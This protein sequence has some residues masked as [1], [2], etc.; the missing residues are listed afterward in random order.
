MHIRTALSKID[1]A[2]TVSMNYAPGYTATISYRDS[3]EVQG[4]D[5]GAEVEPSAYIVSCRNG[6]MPPHDVTA[7]AT[8]D[9]VIAAMRQEGW[10]TDWTIDDAE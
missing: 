5:G 1:D 2:T 7:Y 4:F 6:A 9:E 3:F 8:K 10:M